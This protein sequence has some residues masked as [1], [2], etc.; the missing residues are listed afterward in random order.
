[1]ERSVATPPTAAALSSWTNL[2]SGRSRDAG[3]STAAPLTRARRKGQALARSGRRGGVSAALRCTVVSA[4]D[5][6]ARGSVRP[7]RE[8]VVGARDELRSRPLG[9]NLGCKLSATERNSEQLRRPQSAESQPM[10]L[11]CSGW[12]PGGRR[13]KSCLPDHELPAKR[14]EHLVG[15]LQRGAFQGANFAPHLHPAA[16]QFGSP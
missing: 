5:A 16:S 2:S 11:D 4:R 1:M 12:G 8:C 15:A 9:C 14:K 6:N 10:R 13:F 7:P 3:G